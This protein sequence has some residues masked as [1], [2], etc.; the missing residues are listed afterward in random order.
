MNWATKTTILVIEDDEAIRHSLL[1]L[2]ELHGFRLKGASDGTAGLAA[3]RSELPGLIITDLQ[4][5]GLTGFDLLKTL[6]NDESMRTIPVIVISA[7]TDRAATRLAMELGAADFISKP[8]SEEEV[9]SAIN[10]Q[11]EKKELLDEFDAFAH[12]V[13]HDLKS[14]LATLTGRLQLLEMTLGTADEQAM[15]QN[16]TE[17]NLAAGRLARIIDELLLLAGV[18]RQHAVSEPLDM[19]AIVAES[20][21][22]L[23]N[24]IQR[25]RAVVF[26]PEAWP[27]AIGYAPWITHVWTNY[28]SNAV[29]YAGPE[30]QITLG[31]AIRTDSSA[32]RFWV[33]DRGP[34]LDPASQAALFIPFTRLSTV[35]A[36]GQG[37]GLSIV[38]RIVEKLG[39]RVGVESAPGAGARFW[40]ELPTGVPQTET[41][42]PR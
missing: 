30:A 1:D 22:G 37:L 29:K 4:M 2:L 12:T 40:F 34:G 39:G 28:L 14:P 21:G 3:A 41:N 10:I 27:V 13:A 33:Q 17:A 6:R 32:V 38:R 42:S 20:L 26:T 35:H 11:L 18:R 7:S 23:E 31:C 8:F 25:S 16:L 19:T 5:P 36:K 24:L 15:R 9:M